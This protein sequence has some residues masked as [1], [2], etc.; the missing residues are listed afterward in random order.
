MHH[1]E[2]IHLLEKNKLY[3]SLDAQELDAL[4]LYTKVVS[5]KADT[6]IIPQGKKSDGIY[7]LLHGTITIAGQVVGEG[8][9][10]LTCLQEGALFGGSSVIVNG[11]NAV[12]VIAKTEVHCLFMSAEIFAMLTVFY[13]SLKYKM[14]RQIAENACHRLLSVADKIMAVTS[15]SNMA[16]RTL[17]DS[18]VRSFIKPVKTTYEEQAIDIQELQLRPPFSLFTNSQNAILEQ[19]VL[20]KAPRQCTLIEEG[21]N[22][23]VI[24]V[25]LRGAV[26]SSII[27]KNKVAKIAI[28]GP[29]TL[30]CPL[31]LIKGDF[32]SIVNYTTCE[33]ALLLKIEK[34]ILDE[35]QAKHLSFWYKLFDLVYESFITLGRFTEKLDIRLHS[36]IYNR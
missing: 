10:D 12:S 22:T 25:V 2:I 29:L 5:I 30:F 24:Y 4:I 20:I 28:L 35:F 32:P 14:M 27:Q 15:H 11:P 34:K 31:S 7:L 16:K 1:S 19:A 21:K 17:L 9:V 26:Q 36:E 23:P 3:Q 33:R 6:V 13:P 8:R 18:V